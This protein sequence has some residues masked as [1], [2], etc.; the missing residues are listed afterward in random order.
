MSSDQIETLPQVGPDQGM[1][2]PP[3]ERKGP[4][5]ANAHDEPCILCRVDWT[6]LMRTDQG[7]ERLQ[8]GDRRRHGLG[9][10]RFGSHVTTSRGLGLSADLSFSMLPL[11]GIPINHLAL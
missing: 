10:I 5:I 8:A 9:P 1:T 7:L 3:V 4:D 6:R 11:F 2:R